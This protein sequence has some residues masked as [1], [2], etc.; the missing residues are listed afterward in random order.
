MQMTANWLSSPLIT[1]VI[2]LHRWLQWHI[3]WSM[4]YIFI[5]MGYIYRWQ[6]VVQ[7]VHVM[8]SEPAHTGKAVHAQ[9][10]WLSSPSLPL[11]VYILNSWF[12]L[13]FHYQFIH[14]TPWKMLLCW[15]H[16]YM[17]SYQPDRILFQDRTIHLKIQSCLSY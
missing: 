17:E 16:V 12:H 14:R 9:L 3:A 2:G 13:S 8:Y 10:Y 6:L 4:G 11:V 1:R 5:Y 7:G 15:H